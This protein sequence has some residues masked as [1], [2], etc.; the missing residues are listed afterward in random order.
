[1]KSH[2][3]GRLDFYNIHTEESFHGSYLKATGDF[4]PR[5][6]QDLEHFFRCHHTGE[7]HSIDPGLFLL[8]DALREHLGVPGS[9]Y[10]LISGYRSREYNRLLRRSSSNVS[11]RSYHL[12]GKAADVKLKGV[13][14]R[15]LAGEAR[16]LEMG[17]VGLYRHFVHLDVG[18]V[19]SW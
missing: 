16:R 14:L 13:P 7:V 5:A 9:T 8:L 1:M 4:D 3:S 19:R 6:L 17:G 18:P 12:R 10:H 15:K 2:C 11:K